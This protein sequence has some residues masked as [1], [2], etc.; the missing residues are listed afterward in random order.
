MC[1][2]DALPGAGEVDVLICSVHDHSIRGDLVRL[3][4]CDMANITASVVKVILDRHHQERRL[5]F[6]ATPPLRGVTAT[7]EELQQALDVAARKSDLNHA[8]PQ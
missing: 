2:G 1:P 4:G 3:K 5:G 6:S 7:I 8:V